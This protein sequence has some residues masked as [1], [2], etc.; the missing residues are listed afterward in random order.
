MK[1]LLIHMTAFPFVGL[2]L[3]GS[4]IAQAE[5][6]PA[7]EK[8]LAAA[9]AECDAEGGSLEIGPLAIQSTDLDG[10]NGVTSTGMPDDVVV[11]FNDIF[12]STIPSLWSGTGGAPVHFVLDGTVSQSWVS[13]LWEVERMGPDLPAVILI[14]RHGSACD[15]FGAAPC[16]QAIVASNGEFLTVRTPDSR[17]EWAGD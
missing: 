9:A 16:V 11:N 4:A 5:D 8:I 10:D 1:S 7:A 2:A 6:Y 17:E 14:S 15:S 12:C 13:F 3:T